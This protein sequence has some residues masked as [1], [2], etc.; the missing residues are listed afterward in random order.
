MAVQVLAPGAGLGGDAVEG[1]AHVGAHVVVPVLVEAQR[2]AR[3]LHEQVQQA[4]AVLP[5]LGHGGH[6]V[7]R[8]QVRPARARRQRE[9]LLRPGHDAAGRRRRVV[10]G[11]IGTGGRRRGG[12]VL[13]VVMVVG[14]VTITIAAAA[15]DIGQW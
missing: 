15:E 13:M 2:A 6:H 8:H 4:H 11:G 14:V 3:V 7:V 5:D 12:L 10:I 1:V 9:V